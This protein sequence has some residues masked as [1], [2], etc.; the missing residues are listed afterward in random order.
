MILGKPFGF[1][2]PLF[3]HLETRG[4]HAYFRRQLWGS[5]FRQAKLAGGI[6]AM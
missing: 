5:K 1:E 3:P 6:P 2:V 4:S